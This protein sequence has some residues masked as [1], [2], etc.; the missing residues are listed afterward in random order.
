MQADVTRWR[1]QS[2]VLLVNKLF[3]ITWDL[4]VSTRISGTPVARKR[5]LVHH[6][7]QLT[8]WREQNVLLFQSRRFFRLT[9]ETTWEFEQTTHQITTDFTKTHHYIDT[10][11]QNKTNTDL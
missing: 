11:T 4:H 10:Q 5:R 1:Q 7:A 9:S 8:N 3:N 2:E 6:R